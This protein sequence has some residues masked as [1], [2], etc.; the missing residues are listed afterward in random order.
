MKSP[1][2]GPEPCAAANSAISACVKFDNKDMI[3]YLMEN[4]KSFFEIFHRYQHI[5]NEK[6][7]FAI[8][9]E[10]IKINIA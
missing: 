7:I 4:V 5:C 10:R 1:S 2:H 6:T 8:I 3:A 9:A